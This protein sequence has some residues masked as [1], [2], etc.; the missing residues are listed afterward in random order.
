MELKDQ[1]IEVQ[2]YDSVESFLK[3]KAGPVKHPEKKMK[4]AWQKYLAEQMPRMQ[5]EY[6]SL[7]KSQR[8]HMLRKQ[9][10]KSPDNPTNWETVAYNTK[11][12]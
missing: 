7:K 5:E 10:K 12:G 8:A 4:A 9:W 3:A 6:P 1:G 2:E 11:L